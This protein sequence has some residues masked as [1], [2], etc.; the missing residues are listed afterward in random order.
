MRVCASTIDASDAI[1][2]ACLLV[3]EQVDSAQAAAASFAS[4][5][6]E[7]SAGG[8]STEWST[9]T[10]SKHFSGYSRYHVAFE[11]R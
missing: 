3:A 5:A 11:L 10:Q 1:S 8:V 2:A 7:V 6:V 4:N 9:A